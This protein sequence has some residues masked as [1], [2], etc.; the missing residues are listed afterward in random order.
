MIEPKEQTIYDACRHMYTGF[1]KISPKTNRDDYL[2][3]CYEKYSKN[4]SNFK[5]CL[6]MFYEFGHLFPKMPM[7]HFINECNENV[8]NINNKLKRAHKKYYYHFQNAH[9]N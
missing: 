1:S 7:T 4:V 5:L 6:N 8:V 9:K 2:E 3:D